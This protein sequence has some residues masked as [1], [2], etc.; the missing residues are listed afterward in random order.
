M[1]A[2]CLPRRN[3]ACDLRASAFEAHPGAITFPPERSVNAPTSTGPSASRQHLFSAHDHRRPR[4][5]KATLCVSPSL[6]VGLM[7][8][9][10]SPSLHLSCEEYDRP[11]TQSIVT[12]EP[13]LRSPPSRSSPGP[14]MCHHTGEPTV[15]STMSAAPTGFTSLAC[16]PGALPYCHRNTAGLDKDK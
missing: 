11:V 5:N 8:I 10:P 9:E 1:Q 15:L 12:P 7:Y 3:R 4:S 14:W 2:I 13:L 6:Y 16:H